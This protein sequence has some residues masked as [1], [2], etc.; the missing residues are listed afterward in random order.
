M[1]NP[2]I[3]HKLLLLILSSSVPK[4]GY[5]TIYQHYLHGWNPDFDFPYNLLPLQTKAQKQHNIWHLSLQNP[6][7]LNQTFR[8]G[9]N[10]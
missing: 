4:N 9:A 6:E 8:L 10:H 3:I 5:V 1:G 2:R 7:E